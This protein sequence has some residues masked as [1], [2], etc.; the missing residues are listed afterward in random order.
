FRSIHGVKI[1]VRTVAAMKI[2]VD[3]PA[4]AGE[5]PA[6]MTCVGTTGSKIDHAPKAAA[7]ATIVGANP[8]TFHRLTFSG[9][10]VASGPSFG[11]GTAASSTVWSR[12]RL[13]F[14]PFLA[15]YYI[16]PIIHAIAAA[17][18]ARARTA[19]MTVQN[20]EPCL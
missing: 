20:F 7:T 19:A 3:A 12:M 9:A 8:G 18:A 11:A 17:V 10:W 5:P 13:L 15:N 16:S 14:L 2:P 6:S 4:R 1:C